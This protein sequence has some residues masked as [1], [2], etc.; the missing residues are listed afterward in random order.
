MDTERKDRYKSKLKRIHSRLDKIEEWAS[1]VSVEEFSNDLQLRLSVYKAVQE[2]SEAITDINAMYLSDKDDLVGDNYENLEECS[3]ELFS[4]EI[5]DDLKRLNGL[6]N[7]IVHEYDKIDHSIALNG[8]NN[9]KDSA[10]KFE[11]EVKEWIENS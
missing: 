8:I 11:Q 5:L 1:S 9:T 3:G 2:V 7:R 6:R 10:A 4:D